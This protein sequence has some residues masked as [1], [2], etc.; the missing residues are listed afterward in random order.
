MLDE[1][2]HMGE[3]LDRQ[4]RVLA[5]DQSQN[6]EHHIS[7]NCIIKLSN[8]SGL[9]PSFGGMTDKYWLWNV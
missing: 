7:D 4:S 3:Y 1:Y 6:R 8:G 9:T 2:T 5:H